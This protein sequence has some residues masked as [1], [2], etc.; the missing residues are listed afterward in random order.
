MRTTL[1]ADGNVE[2]SV[3][4]DGPGIAPE[5]HTAALL[6]HAARMPAADRAFRKT[7]PFRQT[8]L[9]TLQETEELL[10]V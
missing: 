3:H 6:L 7:G 2:F 10:R 5:F 8:F 9:F 4:D 1:N